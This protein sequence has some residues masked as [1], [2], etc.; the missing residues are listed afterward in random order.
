MLW[1]NSL[2]LSLAEISFS[3]VLGY[4]NFRIMSLKKRKVKFK[5]R[6]KLNHNIYTFFTKIQNHDLTKWLS[7]NRNLHR[8]F[9]PPQSLSTVRKAAIRGLPNMVI[10]KVKDIHI[11]KH[12]KDHR[13]S[14]FAFISSLYMST[15]GIVSSYT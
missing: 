8:N 11:N 6:T 10:I 5:P 13:R 4:G 2:K 1:F 9:M 12:K 7:L 3:F 15:I 14:Y